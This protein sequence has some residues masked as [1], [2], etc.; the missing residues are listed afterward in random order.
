M[1]DHESLTERVFAAVTTRDMLI[2]LL[3]TSEMVDMWYNSQNA[4]FNFKRP[5]DC[6]LKT[7]R[8]YVESQWK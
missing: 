7:V 6:D 8:S 3:G 2:S 1:D 5:I 4:N